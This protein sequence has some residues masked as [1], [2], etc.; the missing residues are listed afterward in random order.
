MH[1]ERRTYSVDKDLRVEIHAGKSDSS[2]LL[3][4]ISLQK[5]A[6][7]QKKKVILIHTLSDKLNHNIKL[8]S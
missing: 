2:K 7:S 8:S 1:G 4:L 3:L 5:V 6:H